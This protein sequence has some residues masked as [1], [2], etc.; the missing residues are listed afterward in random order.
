MKYS[1][2]IITTLF[3]VALGGVYLGKLSS[4]NG[5]LAR[6]EK[7]NTP[8]VQSVAKVGD[9]ITI[10][11]ENAHI[12]DFRK[13]SGDIDLMRNGTVVKLHTL[14]ENKGVN[15]FLRISDQYCSD[16]IDSCKAVLERHVN[17]RINLI[18]LG[19][20]T[21]PQS[22]KFFSKKFEGFAAVYEVA[23]LP[24]PGEG[25]IQPYFFLLSK[26]GMTERSFFPVKE[27]PQYNDKYFNTF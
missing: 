22:K 27:Y 25:A 11:D 21:T 9:N 1:T 2:V 18:V 23:A 16:C 26:D 6:S 4:K 3:V 19:T 7:Q 15:L 12:N 14:N 13:L 8:P 20:F 17:E 10:S 24:L 5:Q